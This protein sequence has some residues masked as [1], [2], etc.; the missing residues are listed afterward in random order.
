MSFAPATPYQ[1]Y[2]DAHKKLEGPGDGR[3][4][5]LQI[6]EDSN[7]QGKLKGKTILITGT[8][9][10]IGVETARALYETGAQL[11]L[12][13][14]DI[15]KLEKV[16]QDIVDNATIKDAPRPKPLELHLDSLDSVR[17]G[18]EDFKKQSSQ[19]NILINNAG[20]MACPFSKTQDDFELQ[21]GTNHF[22]HFLFFQLL[23]PLLLSSSTPTFS[24]RLINLSSTGHRMGGIRFDDINFTEPDSYQKWV[25]YGQSKTANIYMASSIERHYGSKGLHGLSVHPGGIMTELGRHLEETDLASL[26]FDKLEHIFKSPAQGA[27]TTVWAAVSEHFEGKNGGRYLSDCGEAG[28]LAP[29]ADLS[30]EGYAEHIYNQ[31]KEEK[32]WKLSNDLLGLPQED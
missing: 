8:S 1:P 13:A 18:A 16:I 7:A 17:K 11:F 10:G 9:S 6:I 2:A 24:S 25:A 22:A 4:T 28:P 12:T 27:A 19:L 15:P 14:R 5:A 3:P 32:F 21:I 29:D 23:K 20:V 30:G 26:G 31:E